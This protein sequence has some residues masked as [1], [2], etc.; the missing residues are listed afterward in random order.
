MPGIFKSHDLII[1]TRVSEHYFKK[2]GKQENEISRFVN[3]F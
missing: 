3:N 1:K 2:C